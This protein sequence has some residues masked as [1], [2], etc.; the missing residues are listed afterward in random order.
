MPPSRP[1]RPIERLLIANRGEIAIRIARAARESGIVPLGIYSDADRNAAHVAAMDDALRIGPGPASES[2]LDIKRVV[3][4]AREL[5]A[6]AIHPGY[7]F[8]S[9]RAPFAQAVIDAGL[10]FV[11]PTPAAIA[12]MGDKSEAKRRV[13]AAG[14]PVVPGYDGDDQ[15]PAHLRVEAERIGTPVLIKASA[16][17]GGRGMRVVD[18]VNTFAEALEAAR[19]EALGAF[20]DDR[21]LLEKYLSRPR[22]IEFQIVA[23]A[24]GAIVHFG[25][26]ECS[27]QRRHQKLIEEAPSVALDAALRERMGAA[28]VAAARSVGYTNL[29][30][31]EFLLDDAGAF[32]FLEM[33]ARLQV[34]HPVTESVYGIDL[35]RLQ[36]ALAGGAALEYR[37]EQIVPRGWAIEARINAEDPLH[38]YLPA[39]GTIT[40]WMVPRARDAA[41]DVGTGGTRARDGSGNVRVDAGVRDGSDVSI[42][43]DSLLAKVIASGRDRNAAVTQLTRTLAATRIAGVPTNVPLLLR[44]V[45]DPDFRRGN[46]TTAFLADHPALATEA[47]DGRE[48]PLLIALG[49][50]LADQRSWRVAGIGVPIRLR[51]A[52]RDLVLTASRVA[53]QVWRI[54]GDYTGEVTFEVAASTLSGATDVGERVVAR[55]KDERYA[56]R[57][58]VDVLGVDV[59]YDDAAYRFAFAAP[60]ALGAGGSHAASGADAVVSPMPGKIV[61]VAVR[62]GERV[63]QRDLLV[64]L[65]AMK[66]E[67]RIEA[68]R[69]GTVAC[70]KVEAG[71]LVRG[72]ATLVELER[73][74]EGRKQ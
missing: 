28:A 60:P 33:N 14:V 51:E 23:D 5:R 37:Q 26:R 20:G 44:I 57:A 38:G 64:V 56:G 41:V 7:G 12:A 58:R 53:A 34:E 29:G 49:A 70:V 18:D 61:K 55:T 71:T 31:V 3:A 13:R 69:D 17:G 19:R 32:Y 24:Y 35:V 22:H 16:G 30:T 40:R 4:A 11:G 21:V 65:E 43:Y 27:I 46:T 73:K 48:G 68:A 25:E 39:A 66:M 52:E 59:V 72:G 67:H 36:L 54:E 6:D 9:E 47:A 63:A 15:S 2:Y 8:L 1:S 10:T 42:F 62:P 74:T 45:R 50:V